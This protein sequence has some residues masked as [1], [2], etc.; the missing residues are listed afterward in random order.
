MQAVLDDADFNLVDPHSKTIKRV[1]RARDLWQ[2]ILEVR[3]LTGEPYIHFI[4]R[5]NEFLNPELKSQGFKVNH[6]NLCTEILLPTSK[7]YSNVCI[8][9][10]LNLEEWDSWKDNNLFIKDVLEYLDN[11]TEYFISNAPI[12]IDNAVRA[13]RSE[14]SVGIGTMGFHSLLQSKNIPFESALAESLN[15]QIFEY[16]KTSLDQADE[17]LKNSRGTAELLEKTR[18]AHKIAIAP[19]SNISVIMGT[20]PS[21]EPWA[22]NYFIQKTKSGS[23]VIKNRYL[24][25]LLRTKY[26]SNEVSNVWKSIRDNQGSVQHLERLDDWEKSVFK[27]AGE[28]DQYW[29]VHHASV[30]QPYIDQGQS[31]NLFFPSNAD[32]K[33]YNQ[34]HIK[35]WKQGLKTLYYV[36]SSAAR[37]VDSLREAEEK[38]CLSCV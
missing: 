32:I 18:F 7:G 17:E 4:D 13:S 33:Y 1:I 23:F 14:R 6:S 38:E 11:V 37:V 22:S 12:S 35:A 31:V 30:R 3:M 16:I 15:R 27:T 20:S 21:I 8:L 24:D 9:S 34:A 28:L 19:N 5:S 25:K 2:R 36:R 10:S 26:N 29:V